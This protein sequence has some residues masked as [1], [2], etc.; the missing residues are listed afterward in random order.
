VVALLASIDYKRTKRI[1]DYVV[2]WLG[3]GALSLLFGA[4]GYFIEQSVYINADDPEKSDGALILF[5]AF[6]IG[7]TVGVISSA[8]IFGKHLLDTYGDKGPQK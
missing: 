6:A 7:L 1:W 2:L 5:V 8:S 3:A 4:T